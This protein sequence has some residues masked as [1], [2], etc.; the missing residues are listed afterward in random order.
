MIPFHYSVV[1]NVV[2]DGD[3]VT[4]TGENYLGRRYG[5]FTYTAEATN[6]EFTA[7]YSSC[8]DDGQ[9]VLTRC[10]MCECCR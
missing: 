3:T 10:G 9:F 5:T 2:S 1:L 7:V 8:K 4:L 6:D